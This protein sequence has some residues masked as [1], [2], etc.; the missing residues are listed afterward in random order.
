MEEFKRENK[1]LVL[2]HGDIELYLTKR[3]KADL[4]IMLLGIAK[5]RIDMGKKP[6]HYVVVNED[7]PY[8]EQVWQL[9]QEHWEAS[10]ETLSTH[11]QERT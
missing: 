1:Y 2:K 7:E 3:D 5:G 4:N 10:N 11:R 8:A 6:N 9:I